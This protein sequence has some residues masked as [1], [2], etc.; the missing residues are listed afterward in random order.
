[1]VCRRK[2]VWKEADGKPAGE[3]GRHRALRIFWFLLPNW[4]P[5]GIANM[6]YRSTPPG[7]EVLLPNWPWQRTIKTVKKGML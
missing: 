1:M 2:G 5:A 3:P 7:A 6:G 4:V